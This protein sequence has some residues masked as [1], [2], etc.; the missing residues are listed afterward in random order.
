[1]TPT[2][3]PTHVFTDQDLQWFAAASGDWNPIH[4]DAAAARR[5][6][7]GS[8]VVHGVLML[9]TAL[10]DYVAAGGTALR[11]MQVFFSKAVTCGEPLTLQQALLESGET[12]LSLHRA[13]EEV[14][15]VL[16]QHSTAAFLGTMGTQRPEKT[17]AA[18]LTFAALKGLKGEWIL[19]ADA[20]DI[21]QHF[22]A[23]ATR[24]GPVRVA[25]LMA[26]SRVVGMECPG[27]HSL[28]TGMRLTLDATAETRQ[29]D[30]R[31]TRHSSAYAPVQITVEGGG[32][33]G[34]LEA[35]VR[36]EP[37]QQPTLDEVRAVVAADTYRG[38]RALVVGGSRGLG[39]LVAKIIIAGGGEVTVTYAQGAQDAAQLV[40]QLGDR[41][42]AMRLDMC[43]LPAMHQTMASLKMLPTHVYYFATP[44]IAQHRGGSFDEA[45][46]RAYRAIYVEAWT[47]LVESLATRHA[48][49]AF[50]Y[51]SSVF[52]DEKPKDFMEYSAAKE[53][54]ETRC[55]E[56]T[57]RY[58]HVTIIAPRLPRLRTDQTSSL[59]AH[60]FKPALPVM[61]DA[62]HPLPCRRSNDE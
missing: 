10:E 29:F 57:A 51:P 4:V 11:T 23:L 53:A 40:Q 12:R 17:V 2:H 30:W 47:A 14:M 55:R 42:Q 62:I 24:I 45:A 28:F 60:H 48:P 18:P 21:A 61:L 9:L 25:A 13:G 27:V 26:C 37:V 59:L 41:S 8:Q 31:V 5:L 38:Q 19:S 32:L 16:L 22:P 56:L 20:A 43:D 7:A 50:F 44:R 54:G 36:P 49:I 35:M 34:T 46:Y 33:R 52:V 1:M 39:E 6:I 58:P 15:S 3:P